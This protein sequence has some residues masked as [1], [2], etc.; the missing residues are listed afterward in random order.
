MTAEED[1]K[2]TVKCGLIL[3]CLFVEVLKPN[4]KINTD[5]LNTELKALNLEQFGNRLPDLLTEMEDY[6]Q[7]IEAKKARSTTRTSM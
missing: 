2:I 6:H 5:K 3:W 7:R 1:E 4:T